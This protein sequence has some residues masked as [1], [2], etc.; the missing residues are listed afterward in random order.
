MET[1]KTRK[2][3]LQIFLVTLFPFEHT[4][5]K[6]VTKV[7]NQRQ[8]CVKYKL[9]ILNIVYCKTYNQQYHNN[10]HIYILYYKVIKILHNKIYW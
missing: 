7:N 3:D 5:Y 6:L 8:S 9:F 10:T 4:Y 1:N 2:D